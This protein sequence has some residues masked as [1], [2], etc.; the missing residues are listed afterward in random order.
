MK[1]NGKYENK[2]VNF[3]YTRQC[4]VNWLQL[5]FFLLWQFNFLA[6]FPL[7]LSSS[8]IAKN[9]PKAEHA[10]FQRIQ[11]SLFRP[12]TIHVYYYRRSPLS[13]PAK[14]H[15]QIA[16]GPSHNQSTHCHFISH[17]FVLAVGR[18]LFNL[19]CGSPL[20]YP[21]LLESENC[22]DIGHRAC[23]LPAA[24]CQLSA[25]CMW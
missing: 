3:N 24:S 21:L 13:T 18:Q 9:Q 19:S 12:N 6:M 14:V 2:K 20:L 23:A 1:R 11:I 4:S 7:V 22:M 8:I 5:F 15:I 16:C 17:F 10:R 25:V